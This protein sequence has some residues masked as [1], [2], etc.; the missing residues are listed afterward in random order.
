M[1]SQIL[2]LPLFFVPVSVPSPPSIPRPQDCAHGVLNITAPVGTYLSTWK[3]LYL[4]TSLPEYLGTWVPEYLITWFPDKIL[5]QNIRLNQRCFSFQQE[6]TIQTNTLSQ[7]IRAV[8]VFNKWQQCKTTFC[9][10][11]H[12]V[13]T[14]ETL[15]C[16]VWAFCIVWI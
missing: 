9:A 1:L 12:F 2:V 14:R 4:S 15:K 7:L 11:K 3:P 6:A 5:C 16:S 8:L 13:K 10:N